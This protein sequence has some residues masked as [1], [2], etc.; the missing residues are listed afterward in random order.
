MTLECPQC[1]SPVARERQQFCYRCGND[2]REYYESLGAQAEAPP[3]ERN[4][5]ADADSLS[6]SESTEASSPK[7]AD[8]S[9]GKDTGGLAPAQQTMV[10]G[11]L[12]ITSDSE[13]PGVAED[14]R[15]TLRVLLPSGDVFDREVERAEIQMGK[16]P[17]NDIVIADPAVSTSHALIRFDQGVYTV[18]DVGSR[19]GT[20]VNGERIAGPRQLN[21]GDMIGLGLSR[22]TFRLSGYSETGAIQATDLAGAVQPQERNLYAAP[23][24]LTEDSM[25][26]AIIAT[27]LVSKADVE[28]VRWLEAKGRRLYRAI[29]EERLAAE[30]SLRDLMS[31]TFQ[32]PVT[33][34]RGVQID[35]AIVAKLHPRLVVSTQAVPVAM[36]ADRLV[37]AVS[38]P[39]DSISIEEI[40]REA[41]A[42]IE[43]RLATAGE[44]AEQI[45]RHYGPKLIGVLPSGEKLQYPV[46]QKEVEIGKAPHNHIVLTDPTVSNTHAVIIARGGG[47]GIVDLGSRN[48]TF[49]NGER[50]ATHAHTLRHGDKIQ[51]G[52]TVLTFRNPGETTENVTAT[53]APEVLEEVRRRAGI[54]APAAAPPQERNLY[55]NAAPSPVNQERNPYVVPAPAQSAEV[56]AGATEEGGEEKDK[57][58]KKKKKKD[59][60]LKAAYVGAVSRIIAQV[61]AVLLSVGLALYVAQK[62]FSPGT[63]QPTNG[64][65]TGNANSKFGPVAASV[66]FRGSKYEPSG[67]IYIP[68]S[69]S[70]LFVSDGREDEVLWMQLDQSGNPVGDIKSISLGVKVKDPEG[71]TYGGSFFY[72]IG[73]QSDPGG[74]N[75]N[76]LVRFTLDAVNR[77]LQGGAEII[78]D[79][80]A[81]LIANVPELKG[82]GERPGAE[83]GLNIEG[84]A[85]DPV[86]ERLLLGLRSP[87]SN[88]Q[89][90]I[91]PIKVRDPLP[92]FSI[93]KLA[94]AEPRTIKL[95]LG[96][97]GIRDI[98]YDSRLKSF[99]II[100][101]A[102]ETQKADFKLWE[103]NG[104]AN[105]SNADSAPREVAT[106][107][108][109][110]K[111]EGVTRVKIG[112]R[113]FV[114]IV[115]DANAYTKVDYLGE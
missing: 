21:H 47:Y 90:L 22:V 79:L 19:N 64:P 74:G 2:L 50:L 87:L 41:Q 67:V 18:S 37:V 88:G 92:P 97:A 114:F 111:P 109:A 46:N 23:P 63:S 89:A 25:A 48:G 12:D 102:T 75:R 103:W 115:G 6:S 68:D 110:M 14:E 85:W 62:S 84:L 32:I 96:G 100:S 43:M 26:E 107:S 52:Q 65:T 55:A 49:V 53:L 81:Y 36:E 5:Y 99:L 83:D 16:G 8:T 77:T 60:R 35:E 98:Q 38:D 24:P 105:Q 56:E 39:T 94:L 29:I 66:A 45:D 80:R 78:P 30:E 10:I 61:F 7:T 95:S 82:Q 17:R 9:P 13:G 28:R 104:D 20:F 58:K 108:A 57:K 27:G 112:G 40:K 70:V 93:D 69:D 51:L 101:G 1:K 31:N 15:A 54:S 72:V 113:D 3:Q 11:S 73:S 33:R 4:L 91:V 59:D 34:L 42:P 44:I 76:A 71:I 106:L 86:H